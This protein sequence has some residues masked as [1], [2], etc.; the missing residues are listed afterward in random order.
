MTTSLTDVYTTLKNTGELP[1]EAWDEWLWKTDPEEPYSPEVLLNRCQLLGFLVCL[2]KGMQHPA[3]TIPIILNDPETSRL[4]LMSKPIGG[5]SFRELKDTIENLQVEWPAFLKRLP[6]NPN[7]QANVES[8]INLLDQCFARFGALCL[9]AGDEKV[10]D[11]L[12]SVEPCKTHPGRLQIT[13]SCIRRTICTF[14]VFYRHLHLLAVARCVPDTWCDCG[15]S[16]YHLEASGDDF[17]MICMHL[18]LPVAAKMNYKHDFPEMYN[19]VSQVVFFHNSEYQRIPRAK[20]E[21]LDSS[22]S[23][24]VLPALMQLYPLITI[25]YEEDNLDLSQ[26]DDSESLRSSHMSAS[27][28]DWYWLVIAGRIYLI[29]PL[30]NVWYSPN[31]TSLLMNVYLKHV[32]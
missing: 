4:S 26:S 18:G 30:K 22:A 25:K 17:N 21:A 12:G 13:R 15:I 20:L 10:M 32:D 5:M 16:K 31:V 19:H 7:A 23:E 2:Y 3:S 29:D 6:A 27:G 8:V 24:H 1:E 9:E 28:S 11:D 14:M